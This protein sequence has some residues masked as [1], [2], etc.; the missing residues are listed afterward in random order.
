MADGLEF[1]TISISVRSD[2]YKGE[3]PL[4]GYIGVE[5]LFRCT[6]SRK[7]QLPNITLTCKIWI[8]I[9]SKNSILHLSDLS[10]CCE[11][12]DD[13]GKSE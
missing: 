11:K 2:R 1:S 9:I 7:V 8:E 10:V 12:L 3:L 13:K 4:S 6:G 5:Y